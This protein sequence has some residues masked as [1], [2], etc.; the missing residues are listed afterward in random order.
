MDRRSS[1]STTN[2]NKRKAEVINIDQVSNR[3][4]STV[5]TNAERRSTKPHKDQ[6]NREAE[7]VN[8]D[9][10]QQQIQ[11]KDCQHRPWATTNV[12]YDQ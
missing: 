9:Q 7:V 2:H 10:R 12:V 3:P 1:T 5:T 4:K 8:F 11:I 6:N